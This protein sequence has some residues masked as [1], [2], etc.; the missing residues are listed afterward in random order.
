MKIKRLDGRYSARKN[1]GY[2]WQVEFRGAEWKKYF[3][4]KAHANTM[5]GASDETVRHYTWREVAAL[6]K[7]APWAYHYEKSYRPMF[8]YF[9]TKTEMEQCVMMFVLTQNG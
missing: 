9:R 4:L 5:F 8:V 2:E 3:S 7:S 6:L 1:Y